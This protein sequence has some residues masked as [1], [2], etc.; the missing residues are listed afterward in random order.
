MKTE[1]E[2]I[3]Y[4]YTDELKIGG[5]DKSQIPQILIRVIN[6]P[7]PHLQKSFATFFKKGLP[8]R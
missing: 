7:Y 6:Q 2:N 5:Q 3:S 4:N 1:F 8:F